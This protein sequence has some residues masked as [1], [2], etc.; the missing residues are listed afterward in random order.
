LRAVVPL[1]KIVAG[2]GDF[3]PGPGLRTLALPGLPAVGPLICYE[4]IFPAA[5]TAPDRRP[6]WL[7]NLTNDGWFGSGAGPRQHL[8]IASMRAVEQ[9]L[10]LVRV[11]GT[12]ISAVVDP[13]GRQLGRLDVG[14]IGVLDSVLPRPLAATPYAVHADMI[15]AMLVVF[16]FFLSYWLGKDRFETN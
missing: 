13:F 16:F 12:G 1:E 2:A 15:P 8:A 10:P 14:E 11:A 9:G 6:G 3:S 4:A 5:V 7:L